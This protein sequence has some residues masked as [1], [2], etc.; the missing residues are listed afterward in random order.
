MVRHFGVQ[1]HWSLDQSAYAT[2]IVFL[3]TSRSSALYA[4]L[5][6]TAIHAVKPDNIATFLGKKLN[7]NYQDEIGNRYNIRIEG[8]GIKP[9]MGPVSIKLFDKFGRILRSET[10]KQRS[11][12]FPFSST[13]AR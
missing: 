3:P 5:T 9:T 6:R 7:G 10:T 12:M 8:T 4:N 2:D 13:S 1:Y 11:M